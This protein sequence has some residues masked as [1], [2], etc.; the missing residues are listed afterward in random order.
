MKNK[1]NNIIILSKLPKEKDFPR[2]AFE[3]LY[4]N[5]S[6][7][8]W[9]LSRNRVIES[10]IRRHIKN[11]KK[12]S[13]LEVGCGNGIVLSHLERVGLKVAG[14][15]MHMEGLKL[16]RSRTLAPLYCGDSTKVKL[17]KKYNAIGLFD[18]IE[19]IDN[20]VAFLKDCKKFLKL[21]G[22][23]FVTVPAF[24]FIWSKLDA[25]SGHKRRYTKKSLRIALEKA[26]YETEEVQYFNFFLFFPQ[27]IFRRYQDRKTAKIKDNFPSFLN[28][29]LKPPSFFFNQFFKLVCFF[30]NKLINF[31]SFPFG[32]SL[33]IVAR[34]I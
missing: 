5:E 11:V 14:L 34:K 28:E 26:G 25:G 7:H 20:D 19:H 23:V 12:A 24:M 1:E 32:A 21:G 18:V 8:F 22:T 9:F 16:A 33:I 10:F 3:I 29:G 27:L 2:E 17:S 13:F 31:I 30:E 6:E 15:D 4:K